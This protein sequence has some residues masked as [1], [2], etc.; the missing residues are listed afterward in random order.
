MAVDNQTHGTDTLCYPTWKEPYTG[1]F[2]PYHKQVPNRTAL[3]HYENLKYLTFMHQRGTTREKLQASKELAIC[4]KKLQR[5][6][7]HVNFSNEQFLEDKKPIDK[8]WSQP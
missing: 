1:H 5:C 8:N 3:K 4:E 2:V 7:I 6:Y